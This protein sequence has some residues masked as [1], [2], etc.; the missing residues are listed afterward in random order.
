[1]K[2]KSVD[3]C[4]KGGIWSG[5]KPDPDKEM[6]ALSFICL[7]V[8][9]HLYPYVKNAENELSKVFKDKGLE[10]C[11]GLIDHLVDQ[12]F[13]KYNSMQ[14]YIIAIMGTAQKLQD[15]GKRLDNEL[16]AAENS[17]IE[18]TSELVCMK[19]LQEDLRRSSSCGEN[20]EVGS[21]C[22]QEERRIYF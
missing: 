8:E 1:M 18:V 13:E 19:L 6:E 4:Y 10:W 21:F 15:T 3:I 20:G 22:T 14:D 16:I 2:K 17:S 11:I 9:P 7:H 5:K 12:K